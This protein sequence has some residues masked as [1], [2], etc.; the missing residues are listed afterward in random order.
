MKKKRYALISAM[1]MVAIA[2]AACSDSKAD[3]NE[4]LMMMD[5]IIVDLT[6]NAETAAVG[7]KVMIQAKVTQ[8]GE[9]VEDANLVEI[10]ITREGGGMQAKVPVK[11]SQG[12]SYELEKTFKEPG[13][14]RIVSHV[15]ARG[16]HSMPMKE[17]K[18]TE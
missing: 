11:H 18:V 15:T 6:L 7:E 17:L 8:S 9:P 4:E 5:P 1:I 2:L 13:T 12:G 3:K 14:Y 16:Q 10:E